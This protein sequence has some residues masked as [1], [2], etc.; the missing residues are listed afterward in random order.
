M[1]LVAP[2]NVLRHFKDQ[3][4]LK[5]F[6]SSSRTLVYYIFDSPIQE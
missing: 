4:C 2:F 1:L 5:A 3:L 6:V